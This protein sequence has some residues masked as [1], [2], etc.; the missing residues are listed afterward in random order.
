[1]VAALES[2]TIDGAEFLSPH[3]DERLGLVKVA[4]YNYGPCWWES[5]GMVHLVVNLEKW[6]ALPAAYRGV[7]SR[8]CDTVN[9]RML[10]KYDFVNPASLKRLVSAGAA[11]RQ[12]PQPILEVCHR[13]AA[14][15]F[16]EVAAKDAQ[17]K[18]GL[19]SLT[20]FLRDSLSWLQVSDHALDG[21]QIASNGRG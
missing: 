14:E 3:D 15:H 13:A 18:K 8:A 19:D 5:A 10:A 12:F 6:N 21:L 17:F 11:I 20:A 2:N 4:K 16:G 9:L 7:L 1:V